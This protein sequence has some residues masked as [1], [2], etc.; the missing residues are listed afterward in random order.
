MLDIEKLKIAEL[1]EITECIDEIYTT[2]KVLESVLEKFKDSIKES[3][4][5]ISSPLFT[6]KVSTSNQLIPAVDISEIIKRYPIEE[7]QDMY[8][9][10]LS[11]TAGDKIKEPE[12]LCEKQIKSVKFIKHG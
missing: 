10:K 4:E 12:L 5:E 9:I 8:A 1:P 3:W 7:N 2:H 6:I 11:G